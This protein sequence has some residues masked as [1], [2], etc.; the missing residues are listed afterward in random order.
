M[1]STRSWATARLG[2]REYIIARLGLAEPP[3]PMRRLLLWWNRS[4]LSYRWAYHR[5]VSCPE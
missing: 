4:A 2:R 3:P 1:P 5:R